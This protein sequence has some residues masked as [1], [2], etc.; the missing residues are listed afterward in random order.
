MALGRA[1]LV[2]PNGSSGADVLCWRWLGVGE[3]TTG[4]IRVHSGLEIHVE[5]VDKPR[6]LGPRDGMRSLGERV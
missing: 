4:R 6:C 3:E 2:R 5:G 1:A